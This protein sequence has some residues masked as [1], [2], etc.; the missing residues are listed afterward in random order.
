METP[1]WATVLENVLWA[2]ATIL[3]VIYIVPNMIVWVCW[4]TK[5]S[6][7][8]LVAQKCHVALKIRKLRVNFTIVTLCLFSC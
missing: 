1:V 4:K 8:L 2:L 7:K 6:I 5:K 3:D